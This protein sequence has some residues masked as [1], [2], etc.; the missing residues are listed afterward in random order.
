MRKTGKTVVLLLLAAGVL[1]AS[2]CGRELAGVKN[3]LYEWE[4]DGEDYGVEIVSNE[5]DAYLVNDKTPTKG[6]TLTIV[7]PHTE[8]ELFNYSGDDEKVKLPTL[9]VEETKPA[10]SAKTEKTPKWY[11]LED[12]SLYESLQKTHQ[13]YPDHLPAETVLEDSTV[14][15]TV[16][17]TLEIETVAVGNVYFFKDGVVVYSSIN[18]Q[19]VWGMLQPG[20][21]VE[22]ETTCPVAFDEV[23]V[24]LN[25]YLLQTF[26]E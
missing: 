7:P 21:T 26:P 25:G 3:T 18:S 6:E 15:L 4:V 5:T 11:V 1:M 12:I 9:W 16:T 13:A 19:G 23:K 17:N 22:E 24:F 10:A 8:K 14:R 20:E 2:S